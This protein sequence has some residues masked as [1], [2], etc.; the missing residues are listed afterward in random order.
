MTKIHDPQTMAGVLHE[1]ANT[2]PLGNDRIQT[3]Q[4]AL[5]MAD[6]WRIGA[7]NAKVGFL[8]V[9]LFAHYFDRFLTLK[10]LTF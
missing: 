2:F 1:V 4:L 5:T 9:V 7:Q 3:Y 8:L 6:K 10:K